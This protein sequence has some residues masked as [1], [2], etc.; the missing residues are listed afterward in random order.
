M[1]LR[2]TLPNLL[3]PCFARAML[4]PALIKWIWH[5]WSDLAS[6]S[7]LL[8]ILKAIQSLFYLA[9]TENVIFMVK[10]QV[11]NGL[12]NKTSPL[13]IQGT[14]ISPLIWSQPYYPL[15]VNFLNFFTPCTFY[16][17]FIL[18]KRQA[19]MHF[20]ICPKLETPILLSMAIIFA[21]FFTSITIIL[22]KLSLISNMFCAS[23]GNV[24]REI[25]WF[26]NFNLT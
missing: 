19:Y 20:I 11:L 14:E 17:L 21:I 24:L 4:S 7:Q 8:S 12:K 16:T 10:R 5:I 1:D 2:V 15:F 3:S 23:T 22:A 13:Q 25:S 9:H 6:L 26:G 18:D